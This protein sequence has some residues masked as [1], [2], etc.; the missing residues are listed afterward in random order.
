MRSNRAHLS[1]LSHHYTNSADCLYV[2]RVRPGRD[3]GAPSNRHEYKSRFNRC[4]KPT[5]HGQAWHIRNK[6]LYTLMFLRLAGNDRMNYCKVVLGGTTDMYGVTRGFF[7]LF[8]DTFKEWNPIIRAF[9]V[10][11]SRTPQ[12]IYCWF[13]TMPQKRMRLSLTALRVL[14]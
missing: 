7:D 13:R 10:C 2:F 1:T 12:S 14:L 5:R 9:E 11:K 4:G 6:L 8:F 3:A